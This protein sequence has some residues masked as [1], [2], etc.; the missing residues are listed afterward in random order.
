MAE[1]KTNLK[2]LSRGFDDAIIRVKRDIPVFQELQPEVG[3][4]Y[5]AKIARKLGF[6]VVDIA[7]KHIVLR[8]RRKYGSAYTPDEYEEVVEC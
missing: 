2:P 3:K 4:I 5:R 7:G 6:C 1:W 8:K